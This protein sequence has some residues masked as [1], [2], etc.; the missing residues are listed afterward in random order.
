[1]AKTRT[2]RLDTWRFV[3]ESNR[4]E[5]IQVTRPEEV[6]EFERFMEVPKMTILELEQF[7]SVYQPDAK[8]RTRV[9]M[10]VFVGSHIPPPGGITVRT[11][12]LE[13]LDNLD[14][15]SSYN[16]HMQYEKLHPF[17]DCNGR[18]G[19]ALWAWIYRDISLGFLHRWYYQSL[20]G[21]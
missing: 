17:T 21:I 9:G 6:A 11:Q 3:T 1:M 5:N 14:K 13:L 18:S 12:L 16:V 7:V 4:I 8:L 15:L 10:N 2:T 19:R 20:A